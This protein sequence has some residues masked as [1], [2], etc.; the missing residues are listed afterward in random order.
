MELK[1]TEETD[2]RYILYHLLVATI[3]LLV[4]S[5]PEQIYPRY[6]MVLGTTVFTVIIFCS[7]RSYLLA[8]FALKKQ[9]TY[10]RLP[11]VLPRVSLIIPS[12]NEEAVLERTIPSVLSLDYPPDKLELIYVYE[13]ACTDKTEQII[14]AF[15]SQDPRIVPVQRLTRKGGKA[16]VTNYGLQFATGDIIGIFDADH[17][18]NSD[19]LRHAVAQLQAPGV[20]CVRG[21]CRTINRTHNVVTRLVAIERDVIERLCIY[22]AWRIGGFSTF[23]GGHAL[24]RREVFDEFGLFNEDVLTEDIDFAVKLHAAGYQIAV[25]PQMQSWEEAPTSL[26]SLVRQ[27][28]RWTRGWIQVWRTHAAHILKMK[29][30]AFFKRLDILISLTCAVV[31]GLLVALIPLRG[32]SALGF[33]TSCFGETLSSLLWLFV[34]TTPG[35]TAILVWFLGREE[36]STSSGPEDLLLIPLLI[37]YII[38][39]FCVSW[40]CLVDEFVLSWPFAYVKTE[41]AEEGLVLAKQETGPVAPLTAEKR[42]I[43]TTTPSNAP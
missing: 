16:A 15:A 39:S 43:A 34:S 4:L 12:Y 18:L 17:S 42:V 19:L 37:P 36:E 38:F 21:W 26:R 13:S 24:F 20:K 35:I 8:F 10:D 31:P 14:K 32:L 41:R 22:G 27:R 11:D 1:T 29:K 2:S 3:Y 25:L 33:R 28:K 5:L 6:H 23:T 40:I 9:N 30:A 7:A